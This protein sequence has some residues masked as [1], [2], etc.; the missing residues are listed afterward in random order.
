MKNPIYYL[1]EARVAMTISRPYVYNYHAYY[2][3]N[4]LIVDNVSLT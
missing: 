1:A 2:H 4:L 3:Y